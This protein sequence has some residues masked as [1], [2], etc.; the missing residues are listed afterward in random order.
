LGETD[1]FSDSSEPAVELRELKL[2]VIETAQR[3]HQ[4]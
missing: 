3:C 4:T 1:P 2:A